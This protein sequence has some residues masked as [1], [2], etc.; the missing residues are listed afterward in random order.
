MTRILDI[1]DAR[2]DNCA[3]RLIEKDLISNIG[4]PKVPNQNDSDSSS[5]S[6]SDKN[7]VL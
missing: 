2:D 3:M 6:E 4:K 7:S 1:K 5:E